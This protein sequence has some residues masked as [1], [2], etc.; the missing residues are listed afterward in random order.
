MGGDIPTDQG[1]FVF[2]A[3]FTG[4]RAAEVQALTWDRV[5]F[6]R[7]LVTID[8]AFKDR[9]YTLGTTKNGRGRIAPLPPSLAAILSADRS[10][11][12]GQWVFS[13]DDGSPLYYISWYLA[14]KRAAKK[15]GR[16]DASL[17]SLRHTL[18]TLLRSGGVGDVHI[19]AAL[20]WADE[21][22]Q[23]N[24]S[25]AENYD[26]SGMSKAVEKMKLTGDKGKTRQIKNRPSG[27]GT[28]R[29]GKG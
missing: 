27:E 24:Y 29:P 17:H 23:D 14:V 6:K 25:H 19:R 11:S 7:S 18:N 1:F 15:I 22:I 4:A 10:Q 20:G 21:N 3:A 16:P 9:S 2:L 12:T 28:A 26:Y 8:R 5:D 13:N